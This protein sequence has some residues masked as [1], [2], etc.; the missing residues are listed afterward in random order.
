MG[1]QKNRLNETILLNTQNRCLKLWVQCKRIFTILRCKFLFIETNNCLHVFVLFNL[2]F[3]DMRDANTIGADKYFHS[4]GNY[5]AANRGT[6]GR[7]AAALIRWGPRKVLTYTW[8]QK[9][10]IISITYSTCETIIKFTLNDIN[11]VH[12]THTPVPGHFF[13]VTQ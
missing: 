1:T 11:M 5:E 6:G 13:F 8:Q 9:K 3:R 2:S 12:R 10:R 4:R 7:H